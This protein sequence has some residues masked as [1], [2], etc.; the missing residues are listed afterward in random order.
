MEGAGG[1][2]ATAFWT[3]SFFALTFLEGG[4]CSGHALG[5]EIA[6]GMW[7]GWQII[8]FVLAVFTSKPEH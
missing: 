7:P 3:G 8:A 4:T 5:E 6:V 1:E 2:E